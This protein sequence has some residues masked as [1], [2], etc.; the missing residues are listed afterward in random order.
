MNIKCVLVGDGAVGKTN[1]AR[2]YVDKKYPEE[3][4]PTILD[5]LSVNLMVDN[6]NVSIAIW[7]T[8]GLSEYDKLRPLAYPGT[9]VFLLCFDLNNK[10]SADNI[11]LKWKPEVEE[12]C[13]QVPIIL[14]GTKLDLRQN[15]DR[16]GD[17]QQEVSRK[18][19]MRIAKSIRAVKYLECSALRQE[20]VSEV[21]LEAIRAS[22]KKQSSGLSKRVCVII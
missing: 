1:L 7:D 15:A 18:E 3:Y 19:G 20:G 17:S 22:L 16:H 14:V 6:I 12:H 11:K 13:P 4:T 10:A 5:N 21:F 2:T 9:D 8:V